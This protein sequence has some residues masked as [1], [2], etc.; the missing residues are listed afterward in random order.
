MRGKFDQLAG[1][2]ADK[3][4]ALSD[5]FFRRLYGPEY[6]FSHLSASPPEMAEDSRFLDLMS[7]TVRRPSIRYALS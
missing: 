6:Q 3:A 7:E 2:S 1:A 4:S 5:L